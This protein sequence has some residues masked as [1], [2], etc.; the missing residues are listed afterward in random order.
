MDKLGSMNYVGYTATPYGNFL[1]ELKSIYPKDFIYMLPKSGKYIG[2]Q[3]IFGFDRLPEKQADGL[4][5]IR[6][7]GIK[8][9]SELNKIEL[10]QYNPIPESLKDAICWFICWFISMMTF[11]T[12]VVTSFSFYNKGKYYSKCYYKNCSYY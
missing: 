8:D 5:I 6:N 4:N 2:P 7:I 10:G 9:L 11:F 1:N 3:E 12:F